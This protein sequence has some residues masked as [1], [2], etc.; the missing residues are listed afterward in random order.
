MNVKTVLSKIIQFSI[1]TQFSTIWLIDK[2]LPGAIIPGQ[3]E[4]GS[5]GNGGVLLIPTPP[6]FVEPP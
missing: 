5:D 3:S 6:V 2:I 1:S 4:S